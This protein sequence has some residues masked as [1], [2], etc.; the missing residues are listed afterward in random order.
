MLVI[1]FGHVLLKLLD[2]ALP[3]DLVGLQDLGANTM[4][5]LMPDPD[6]EFF[7]PFDA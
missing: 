2:L 6:E 3:L 5:R 7:P 1:L 4:A